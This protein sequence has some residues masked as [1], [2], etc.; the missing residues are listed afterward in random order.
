MKGWIFT[1]EVEAFDTEDL[2]HTVDQGERK[3]KLAI[4]EENRYKR[5]LRE[6]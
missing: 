6:A 3:L 2:E 4:D 5:L 1:N